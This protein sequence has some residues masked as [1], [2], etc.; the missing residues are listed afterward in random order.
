MAFLRVSVSK[1]LPSTVVTV[2]LPVCFF[3]LVTSTL[4]EAILGILQTLA[5]ME[6]LQPPQCMPLTTMLVGTASGAGVA[7]VVEG[8]TAAAF[9]AQVLPSLQAMP[10]A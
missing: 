8:A 9:S 7:V 4:Q 6:A 10:S 3:M 5:S 2:T 1:A